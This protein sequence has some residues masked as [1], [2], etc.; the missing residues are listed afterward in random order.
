MFFLFGINEDKVDLGIDQR[1]RCPF[2]GRKGNLQLVMTY[3]VFTLFFLPLFK[4]NR[5]YYVR[6]DCCN[7]IYALNPE[8][9]RYIEAYGDDG[10]EIEESDLTLLQD[11]SPDK[12]DPFDESPVVSH[13]KRCSACGSE[14]PEEFSYC[15][16][17][18]NKL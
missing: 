6:F 3:S 4:W 10:I 12:V 8:A 16:H 5:Q 13:V 17:C 7:A 9:G 14:S 15:P 2:C 18:G 1:M 11:G